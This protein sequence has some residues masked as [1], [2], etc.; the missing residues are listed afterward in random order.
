MVI[1]AGV[2]PAA[3]TM[4]K[5][6]STAELW[7]QNQEPYDQSDDGDPVEDLLETV[8][9]GSLICQPD[10]GTGDKDENQNVNNVHTRIS[11]L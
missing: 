10:Q 3:S 9:D 8:L 11:M 2:A 1:P 6:R 4:S 7:D 5:L